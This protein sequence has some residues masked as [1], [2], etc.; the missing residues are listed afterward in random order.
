MF[1]AALLLAP[2]AFLVT[3]TSTATAAVTPPQGGLRR[4]LPADYAPDPDPGRTHNEFWTWQFLFDDG[5][6]AQLNFSRVHFGSLKDP[7]CGADLAVMNFRGRNAFV[8]REYPLRNF[9]WEAET[10][11]LAMHADIWAE[12][13]PPRALRVHFATRKDGKDYFLDLVFD[14]MVPGAVWGDGVFHMNGGE[15]AALFLHVPRGRV[16]GRLGVGGDTVAVRGFGSMDHSRQSQ[17]ATRFMDAGYRYVVTSGR[18]ESGYFLQDGGEVSGYGVR[19]EKGTL[20]LLR[21]LSVS[22]QE[23]SSWGGLR[24]PKRMTFALEGLPPLSLRRVEDRQRTSVLQELG[25]FER[26]GARVYL[27]GEIVGYRGL[28]KVDDS[29]PA[30]F[31]FTMVKR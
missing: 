6:Q 19:E 12:G 25:A 5:T 31:S 1:S 2:L 28:A 15:T 26:F 23:R 3:G 22:V 20:T 17:F 10:G 9:S 13:I 30:M 14:S 18:A 4:D 29:L 24:V 27:G 11:R 7:V 21:P 8:A 16:H